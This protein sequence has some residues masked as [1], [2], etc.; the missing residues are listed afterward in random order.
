MTAG[1]VW[2]KRMGGGPASAALAF[3]SGWDVVARPAADA[4]LATHDLNTNAAHLLMLAKRRILPRADAVKLAKGLLRI[5]KR[6]SDGEDILRPEC[7]DI[8]MSVESALT[9]IVGAAAGRIHTARSRNDQAATDTLLWLREEVARASRGTATLADVLAAHAL[10]HTKTCCPGFSHAQPAM[11]T[12]WGHW[13]ASHLAAI[14]R[15]QAQWQSLLDELQSCPLGAAAG[16][17]TSWPI[18]RDMTA[19][20]LGFS[21]PTRNSMDS[22]AMRGEFESRFANIAAQLLGVLARIAQDIIFLASPP[23]QWL[24]LDDAHVTGSSIMPQKRNPDFAEVTI[25][26][27]AAARAYADALLAVP[28]ALPGGYHRG[29]QWTKYLAFDA[30]DNLSGACEVYSE[31]VAAIRADTDAMRAACLTGFLNATDFADLISSTRGVT[32]REAYRLVGDAVKR[33]ESAGELVRDGVDAAMREAKLALLTDAEFQRLNDPVRLLA[34]RDLPGAPAPDRT[35]ESIMAMRDSIRKSA[36]AVTTQ[37]GA[38]ER[39][40]AALWR[41]VGKLAVAAR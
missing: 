29:L 34:S 1:P 21:G 27:A 11:I 22:V 38:Q 31:V 6:V 4:R 32:F 12:S 25:A 2:Q 7:E 26:R 33:C 18:D 41:R 17:G 14:S 40:I 10:K 19:K 8:H 28:P 37:C 13:C 35:R 36:R 30:A 23:R 15:V 9:D 16:F 3:T 5:R 20:L 24:R 39:A